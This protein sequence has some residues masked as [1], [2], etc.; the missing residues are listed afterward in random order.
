MKLI[1]ILGKLV[2]ALVILAAIALGLVY[3]RSSSLMD[4]RIDVAE[5]PLPVP[6]DAAAL[7]HGR[8]VAVTRGCTDCH[9]QDL[10][11]HVLVDEFPIGRIA[12]PNLTAGK[13]GLGSRLDAATIERA[14]RHGVG[15]N[16]RLLLYMPASDY[17]GLADADVADLIAYVKSV[18]AV[19][20]EIAAPAAGPLMRVLFLLGKA[21]LVYALKV[22]QHAAHR[23]TMMP[24]PT[25]EYGR[26]VAQA[27]T[28][29]HNDHFSGGHVPGTPPNFPDARNI[30]PDP[31]TGIG[32]WTKAQFR[33]A[34]TTGKRPDGSELNRFMPWPAFATMTDVEIEALWAYLHTVPPVQTSAK[35]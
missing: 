8:H 35:R 3:W 6:T 11:G 27:C 10:G 13:G 30:T 5:A 25:A 1:R 21:P 18:P 29:C 33:A 32:N 34:I 19:D 2:L 17:A 31:G 28:G 20:R 7:E 23:A 15:G 26:Y 14:V 4:Q 22:D 12:A 24:E 16:G 9:G